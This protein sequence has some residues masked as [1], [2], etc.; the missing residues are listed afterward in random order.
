MYQ[1]TDTLIE[2]YPYGVV[3]V[4]RWFHDIFVV[5]KPTFIDE[6]RIILLPQRCHESVRLLIIL[7]SNNVNYF[8]IEYKGATDDDGELIFRAYGDG[9]DMYI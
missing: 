5:L 3:F 1:P 9:F 7:Q 4:D 2:G 8:Y 6:F